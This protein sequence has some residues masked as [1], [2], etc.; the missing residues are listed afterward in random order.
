MIMTECHESPPFYETDTEIHADSVEWCPL[1]KHENILA[2][3]TY[4]LKEATETEAASRFGRIQLYGLISRDEI[5]VEKH[6]AV[7]TDGILD[8]KW[9]K[10]P[11]FKN[12][13]AVL[14]TAD[15][16]GKLN[17][18][19]LTDDGKSLTQ[20]CSA[21][22]TD[23]SGIALSLD[24]ND[25]NEAS[26]QQQP[27]R[28]T[29]SYANGSIGVFKVTD[30]SETTCLSN[31]LLWKAHDFEAWITMFNAWDDNIVYSGGDDCLLKGWDTRTSTQ[32][33][34]N[35]THSAGVCS[36]HC[37][38]TREHIIATGSYDEHVRIWDSRCI[39][40]TPLSETHVGGGVWRLKWRPGDGERLL[41][42]CMHNGFSVL[43]CR[44]ISSGGQE[45]LKRFERHESLAYGADWCFSSSDDDSDK[46]LLADVV[47]SCSFYDHKLCVWHC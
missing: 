41:A 13:I 45:I 7:A 34:V 33:F 21:T 8:M 10:R 18:Y 46:E 19:A 4:Q 16:V 2:G 36:M 3:G 43:D 38:P 25:S 40:R 44:D 5:K 29:V 39:R 47:A 28:I 14:A 22:P 11:L 23:E 35:R 37:H 20:R 42:A 17:L 1:P 31:E 32:I 26:R 15:A 12:E 24:W 30:E 27:T 6:S 9:S